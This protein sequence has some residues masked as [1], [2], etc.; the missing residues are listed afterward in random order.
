MEIAMLGARNQLDATV[1]A[2]KGDE[3][4]V[5]PG[6]PGAEDDTDATYHLCYSSS[7]N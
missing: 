7:G 6:H 3:E 5:A 4:A 1:E 2:V